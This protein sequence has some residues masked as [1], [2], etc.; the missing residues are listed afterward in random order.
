MSANATW[1]EQRDGRF[2]HD[3]VSWGIAPSEIGVII[4]RC[5][6]AGREVP[7]RSDRWGETHKMRSLPRTHSPMDTTWV[8]EGTYTVNF[9]VEMLRYTGR[10]GRFFNVLDDT[11]DRN[12]DPNVPTPTEYPGRKTTPKP[13]AGHYTLPRIKC[14]NSKVGADAIWWVPEAKVFKFG[15]YQ[16][17]PSYIGRLI[18]LTLMRGDEW[19]NVGDFRLT[20]NYLVQMLRRT[21]KS[22]EFAHYADDLFDANVSPHTQRSRP[23]HLS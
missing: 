21:G 22:G 1:F 14:W 13:L 18:A 3:D 23:V 19:V 5:L 7:T 2:H 6:M 20:V 16:A 10:N 11:M 12:F 4:A 8:H 9:L 15:G 17:S